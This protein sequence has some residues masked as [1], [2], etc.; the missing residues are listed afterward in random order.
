MHLCKLPVSFESEFQIR[1]KGLKQLRYRCLRLK[2]PLLIPSA[3]L[4]PQ[5]IEVQ[6]MWP[7]SR[8]RFKVL[9]IMLK[10]PIYE[11]LLLHSEK[12]HKM[13][14]LRLTAEQQ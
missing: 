7:P 10:K 14:T 8:K 12:S 4:D 11:Q 2:T 13:Q 5:E 1:F 6:S 9:L 3:S